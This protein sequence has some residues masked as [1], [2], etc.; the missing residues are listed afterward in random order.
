MKNNY[1]DDFEWFD[2]WCE[3]HYYLMEK[4]DYPELVEHCRERLRCDP[5]DAHGVEAL[6]EALLLNNQCQESI[7][8][9]TPYY[10]KDPEHPL[11]AHAILDALFAMGKSVADFPWKTMP[12]IFELSEDVLDRCYEYLKPKR[13]PRSVT[14]LYVWLMPDGYIHFAEEDLLQAF[15]A[16]DRFNVACDNEYDA[17]ISIA[18]KQHK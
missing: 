17:G 11:Y 7:E 10:M 8:M 12:K 16:D 5:R 6:A 9:L 3:H 13:K 15:K 14:D 18:R 1:I 2:D 4:E